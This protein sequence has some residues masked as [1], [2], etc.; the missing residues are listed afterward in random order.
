MFW[1]EFSQEYGRT[2]LIVMES[3]PN[4]AWGGIILKAYLNVLKEHLSTVL[5][6]GYFMQDIAS[7]YTGD[8]VKAWFKEKRIQVLD[9]LFYSPDV[10]PMENL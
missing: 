7:I 6:S 10:N 5:R 8:I 3:D 1:A 2:D 4:T 9:W